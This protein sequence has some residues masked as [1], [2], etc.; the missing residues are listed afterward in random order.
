VIRMAPS[1]VTGLCTVL[2]SM[3][4]GEGMEEMCPSAFVAHSSLPLHLC[5]QCVCTSTV[6]FCF[7]SNCK[8]W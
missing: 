1:F 5:I 7:L 4:M 3:P 2:I 6:L 8:T